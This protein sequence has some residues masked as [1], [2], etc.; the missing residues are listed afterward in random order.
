MSLTGPDT[1]LRFY[2]RDTRLSSHTKAESIVAVIFPPPYTGKFS[3]Q[4]GLKI[5]ANGEDKYSSKYE[6]DFY[7]TFQPDG[8][9]RISHHTE[10]V[11]VPLPKLTREQ[12]LALRQTGKSFYV[13]DVSHEDFVWFC[14]LPISASAKSSA[15]NLSEKPIG[16]L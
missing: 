1:K 13:S 4:N 7:I 5:S 9:F 11:C 2:P 14:D 3:N 8:S 10:H 6:G 12:L 16:L 15:S